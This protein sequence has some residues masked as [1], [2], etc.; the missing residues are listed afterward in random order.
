MQFSAEGHRCWS[1]TMGSKD[2][3]IHQEDPNEMLEMELF[4]GAPQVVIGVE[5]GSKRGYKHWQCAVD[6]GVPRQFK[7]LQQFRFKEYMFLKLKPHHLGTKRWYNAV[8]YCRKDGKAVERGAPQESKDKKVT[9][10]VDCTLRAISGESL[11]SLWDS[12]PVY[13]AWNWHKLS[14]I[15]KVAQWKRDHP[16]DTD[17][18]EYKRQRTSSYQ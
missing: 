5:H 14:D 11:Y 9:P 4:K 18:E 2:R 8:A 6:F 15:K 13:M 7:E 1:F 16:H 17:F 10:M 12:H 3:D